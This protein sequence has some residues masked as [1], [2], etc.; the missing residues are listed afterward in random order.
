MRT[1]EHELKSGQ[2]PDKV[3]LQEFR[4][5]LDNARLTAWTVNELLNAREREENLEKVLSFVVAERLRR[6]TQMLKELGADIEREGLTWQTHGVQNLFEAV[7][8]VQV[9][10]LELIEEH[11]GGFEQM[12]GAGR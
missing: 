1:V 2:L 11:R 4:N 3:Q 12:K 10:L 8:L 9:H 7:K 6:A 5:V